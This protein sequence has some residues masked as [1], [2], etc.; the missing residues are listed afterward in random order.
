M[1]SLPIMIHLSNIILLPIWYVSCYVARFSFLGQNVASFVINV[2]KLWVDFWKC[3][4]L[5]VRTKWWWRG[6]KRLSTPY[7][8]SNLRRKERKFCF[9][10]Q[11]TFWQ[12]LHF[13]ALRK[14]TYRT[15]CKVLL[16]SST[17]LLLFLRKIYYSS[18]PLK[19]LG[20]Q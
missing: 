5:V 4:S 8:L 2:F 19:K 11:C 7:L 20:A 15:H 16:Y 18:G 1:V 3:V 9:F 14:H 6:T 13:Y 12:T 10:L 17:F